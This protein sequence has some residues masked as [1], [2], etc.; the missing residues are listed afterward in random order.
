MDEIKTL[1]GSDG[2]YYP[3]RVFQKSMFY[4]TLP[5]IKEHTIGI[6]EVPMTIST[7]EINDAPLRLDRYT[8]TKQFVEW[9]TPRFID[10]VRGPMFPTDQNRSLFVFY[11]GLFPKATSYQR[12]DYTLLT[13]LGDIGGLADAL[14]AI[15]MAIVAFFTAF[16]I[17]LKL[18]D[19]FECLIDFDPSKPG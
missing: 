14:L 9:G 12:I 10:E 16:Y 2:D 15:F 3:I 18:I 11:F 17:D 4:Q 8:R 6:Y 19:T 1:N 13:L 5:P 7:L